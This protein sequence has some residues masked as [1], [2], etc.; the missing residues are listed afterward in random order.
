[1]VVTLFLRKQVVI[2]RSFTSKNLTLFFNVF[3]TLIILVETMECSKPQHANEGL[4]RRH[5][6]VKR[7]QLD[8][9]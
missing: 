9:I 1:M 8:Q 3:K 4:K 5:E 7:T 2:K 6:S